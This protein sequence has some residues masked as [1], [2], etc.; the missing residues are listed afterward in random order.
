MKRPKRFL[1]SWWPLVTL[2]VWLAHAPVEETHAKCGL[3]LVRTSS[4]AELISAIL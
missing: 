3:F 1:A 2:G 4:C